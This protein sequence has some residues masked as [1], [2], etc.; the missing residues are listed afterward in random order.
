MIN[1]MMRKIMMR[2]LI[3]KV[4]MK[5]VS[6]EENDERIVDGKVEDQEK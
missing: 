2:K 5:K 1:L 4:M 3:W 6:Y